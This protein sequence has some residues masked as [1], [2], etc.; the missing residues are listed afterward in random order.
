MWEPHVATALSII[1]LSVS[2]Y[3]F[4]IHFELFLPDAM[5]SCRD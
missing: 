3:M 1:I 5:E 4:L 2:G